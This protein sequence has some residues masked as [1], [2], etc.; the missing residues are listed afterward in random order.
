MVKVCSMPH[1][2][3]KV[4]RCD[5]EGVRRREE[6]VVRQWERRRES[7]WLGGES[8]RNILQGQSLRLNKLDD[9][10]EVYLLTINKTLQQTGVCFVQNPDSFD[11]AAIR[12]IAHPFYSMSDEGSQ[13]WW[14]YWGKLVRRCFMCV[15]WQE[16]L[17]CRG[18]YF[19]RF[20]K[21]NTCLNI[22]M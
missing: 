15:C 8:N 7:E 21:W 18:A 2:T 6:E 9:I 19:K 4:H 5:G 22:R 13:H 10:R 11:R 12:R 3:F 14:L 1:F 17:F 16:A 20:K